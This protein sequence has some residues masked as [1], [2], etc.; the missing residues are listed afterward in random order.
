MEPAGFPRNIV[1]AV[2]N[3]LAHHASSVEVV[4][5]SGRAVCVAAVHMAAA[6]AVKMRAAAKTA[7]R[8]GQSPRRGTA[9]KSK[10]RPNATAAQPATCRQATRCHH[11]GTCRDSAVHTATIAWSPSAERP[12]NRS[13]RVNNANDTSGR[14]ASRAKVAALVSVARESSP[15]RAKSIHRFAAATTSSDRPASSEAAHARSRAN[16]SAPPAHAV[17]PITIKAKN[18]NPLRKDA[19]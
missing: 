1:F 9:H 14:F 5:G 18:K 10:Q 3:T 12:C 4:R 16:P 15:A 13:H 6:Q 19:R 11:P 8:H 7:A 2:K 17:T